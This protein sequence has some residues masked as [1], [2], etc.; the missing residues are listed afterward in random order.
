M[1][2]AGPDG[3]V[4]N[5]DLSR[6]YAG[7]DGSGVYASVMANSEYRESPSAGYYGGQATCRSECHERLR[8]IILAFLSSV[9]GTDVLLLYIVMLTV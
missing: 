3:R 8:T 5:R 1:G 4:A 6:N 9:N 7:K 2:V